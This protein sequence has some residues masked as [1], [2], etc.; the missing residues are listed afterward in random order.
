M[1]DKASLLIADDHELIRGGLRQVLARHGVSSL[2]E[3]ENG[4]QA[5]S[6][7]RAQR[8]DV[9]ILDF[10]MP[11]MSGYD[12]ALELHKEG[13]NTAI[14]FLTMHRDQQLFNKA[15]DIDVRGFVL[16]ENTVAEIVQC[17]NTVLSGRYY[18]SPAIS[19]YLLRRNAANRGKKEISPAEQ[20][21]GLTHTERQVL[22]QLATMKTSQEIADY[23][24]VSLKTVQ[25]HR[26][27][28]CSKLGLKGTHAL[29]KFAIENTSEI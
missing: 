4:E 7:I 8:P 17:V 24:H 16:K 27:N 26:N 12:V 14:V 21:N 10:E 2:I 1:L 18:V 5:L 11:L 22:K 29:L 9:A 19:D 23:M 3:A 28:I 25:N 13:H 20:I 15:M 6:L